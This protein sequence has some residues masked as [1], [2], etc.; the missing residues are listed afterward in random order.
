[1]ADRR[2]I[3]VSDAGLKVADCRKC[4]VHVLR[5]QRRRQAVFDVIGDR[6]GI[7]EIV[8]GDDRN[9]GPENLFLRNAHLGI[10][11]GENSG[12]EEPAV[13]I[14]TLV[15]PVAASYKFRAFGFP[16]LD[17]VQVSVELVL[18]HRRTHLD[19]L[20]ET[21]ADLDFLRA[22]DEV[23]DELVVN[24]FLNDDAAGRGAA[25][26]GGAESAPESALDS[27]FEVSVVEHDHRILAAEFERTVLEALGA[28]G[29]HDSAYRRRARERDGAD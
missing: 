12:L 9:H 27:E 5:V 22:R 7:F 23:I 15:E 13:L 10:D 26:S 16:D 19:G 20:V 29:P 21:I 8:A 18:V 3:D 1:R 11:L 25:L 28:R 14:F 2:S 17:V 6:D 24:A 4:L